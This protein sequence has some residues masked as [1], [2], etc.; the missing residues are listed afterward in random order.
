MFRIVNII[1]KVVNG[2]MDFRVCSSLIENNV[3]NKF[4]YNLKIF[5]SVTLLLIK[6]KYTIMECMV[7]LYTVTAV[8]Q[9]MLVNAT[10][11]LFVFLTYYVRFTSSFIS[12][13]CSK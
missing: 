7:A 10:F 9:F 12:L 4:N 3:D 6:I 11:V 13:L 5:F 1:I 2:S 8:K